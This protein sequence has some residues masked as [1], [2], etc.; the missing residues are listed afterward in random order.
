MESFLA[1]ILTFVLYGMH[2]G[3]LE[4]VQK[5]FV[6]ELAPAEYRASG[7]GVFQ[8]F[9]GL[10]ALPSSVVAGVLWD[11]INFFAPFMFS[12]ALTLVSVAML[13]FVKEDKSC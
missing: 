12:L 5:S 9:T 11:Q 3:A 4:P 7:L 2:R 8:L 10:C 1:I 6:S 13:P